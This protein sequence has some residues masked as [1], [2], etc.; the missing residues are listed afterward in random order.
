MLSQRSAFTLRRLFWWISMFAVLLAIIAAIIPAVRAARTAARR[1]SD[2]NDLKQIMMALHDYRVTRGRFPPS[3]TVDGQGKPMHSWR[4]LVTPFLESW[5]IYNSYDRA[6]PW[7]SPSN[8]ALCRSYGSCAYGL[9]RERP[10]NTS[11]TRIVT[12]A[13]PGTFG[14][15]SLALSDIKDDPDKTIA[16][17]ALPATDI[18]WHEPRDLR[19]DE[20][21]RAPAQPSR[22]MI[23]G[24]LFEGGLCGFAD[25]SVGFLPADFDYDTFIALLTVD[26]GETVDWPRNKPLE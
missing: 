8:D 19:L 5:P 21:T 10:S 2:Q 15:K 14:E 26:G 20:I 11:N 22:I 9:T 4:V 25:G 3:I 16:I 7:N 18:L 17:L 23:Q 13:G 12:V 24:R 1:V 6:Q